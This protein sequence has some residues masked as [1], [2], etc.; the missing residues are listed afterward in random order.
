M[1]DPWPLLPCSSPFGGGG[2]THCMLS[3][4]SPFSEVV[5][6]RFMWWLNSQHG[7]WLLDWGHALVCGHICCVCGNLIYFTSTLYTHTPEGYT[8][9][10]L[11][12]LSLLT[13]NDYFQLVFNS[14]WRLGGKLSV[15]L[16]LLILVVQL[17]LT[18]LRMIPSNLLHS[19]FSAYTFYQI[20]MQA[21]YI[22]ANP[23]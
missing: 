13:I 16:Q 15:T 9:V 14:H 4:T 8:H 20:P 5:G 21:R 12:Q 10:L 18:N 7:W 2:C 23:C 6:I 1:L 11:F 3:Q 19:V 17:S 22:T